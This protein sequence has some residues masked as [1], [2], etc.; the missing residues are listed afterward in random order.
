MVIIL[1]LVLDDGEDGLNVCPSEFGRFMSPERH[2]RSLKM[3]PHEG[4]NLTAIHNVHI[5]FFSFESN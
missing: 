4:S 2:I 1:R 5:A 3:P